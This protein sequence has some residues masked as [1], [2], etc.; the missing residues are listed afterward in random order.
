MIF[1][2]AAAA[3]QPDEALLAAFIQQGNQAWLAALY[4]RYSTM[5]Y[6]VCR[7]YLPDDQAA[8]D[9]V[10]DLYEQLVTKVHKQPIDQFRPWLYVVARNHCLMQLRKSRLPTA[11]LNE[12]RFMHL[13]AD[14]HPQAAWE[15]ETQLQALEK[16]VEKLAGPQQQAVRL[17]YLQQ[18]SYHEIA[19]RTGQDWNSVR[20]HIQNGRRN[21][22][23]CME[24]QAND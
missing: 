15:R 7:K 13:P 10:M 11:E 6:G 21:L 16:C 2:K 8:A 4:Q 5:V 17:F 12:E 1:S 24:E 3:Q 18:R 19:D 22:K 23:H 20:S 14:A 9:A